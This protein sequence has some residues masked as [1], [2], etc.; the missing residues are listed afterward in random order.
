MINA[1]IK[2]PILLIRV[3]DNNLYVMSNGLGLISKGG[4][5]F[6]KKNL[7]LIDRDGFMFNLKSIIDRSSARLIDSIRYFQPMQQLSFELE[8]KGKLSLNELKIEIM[9][10]IK[11]K[12]K[13]WLSLGTIEMIEEWT[14]EKETIA[15]LIKMF[16]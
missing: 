8:Q 7:K 15:E 3:N 12:P 6:Y 13:H 4:E 5:T 16:K 11:K 2:Y 10:H 1:D 14:N 9:E